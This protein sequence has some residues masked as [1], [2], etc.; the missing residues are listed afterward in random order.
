MRIK[1]IAALAVVTLLWAPAF[2]QAQSGNGAVKI[3]I[4][5]DASGPYKDNQGIGDNVAVNIALED[6]GKQVLGKDIEVVYADHQHKPDIA[7]G[8]A[9]QWYDVEGVDVVMG[10]GNSAVAL[11]V[12]QLT[13]EKDRINISTAASSSELIGKACSPNG[14]LWVHDTYAVATSAARALT[15]AGLDTWFFITADYAFGHALERDAARIVESQGGKILGRV[16][17]PPFS[18]DLSSFLLQAQASGAKVIGLANAG[19]DTVNSIKQA[20]EFRITGDGKQRAAAMLFL[21]TDVKSAGLQAAQGLTVTLAYYWDLDDAMRSF[22]RRFE[23][24]M[25]RPPTMYHAGLYSAVLHYLKA[26]KA[27]GTDDTQAV[28][29]KM[30]EIPI[31]DMMTKD[32][33]IRE[34]GRV[35]RDMYL[36]EA[37]KPAESK[38]EWDL[39]KKVAVVKAE[40]AAA[41]LSESECPLVK[42]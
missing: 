30:R 39:L 9:R 18:P 10:L 3:G 29:K 13:R 7:V 8:I 26:V 38:S 1:R 11:A 37:K 6:F 4:L 23:K 15:K 35:M 32:G 14:F 16:R 24:E 36:F 40:D 33:R 17:H 12:Q 5:H 31:N 34:D 21:I 42:K 2:S 28:L 22:A 41:P 27:A 25:H 19:V 20:A